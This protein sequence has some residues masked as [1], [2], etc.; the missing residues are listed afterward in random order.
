MLRIISYVASVSEDQTNENRT[1]QMLGVYH[2]EKRST[3]H[4]NGKI[5]LHRMVEMKKAQ[6][7]ILCIKSKHFYM[8]NG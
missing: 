2:H 5:R 4:F 6:N 7:H 8:K 1:W 3:C